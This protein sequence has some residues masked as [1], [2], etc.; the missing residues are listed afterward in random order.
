MDQPKSVL[1]S[2]ASHHWTLANG[3]SV[4]AEPMPHLRSAA[5][6]LLVPAGLQYEPAARLGLAGLACE[7]SQRGAGARD[8]RALLEA[9]DDLGI[10][11]TSS[12]GTFHTAFAG[13]MPH[14]SLDDALELYAD[15]VQRP[16]LP[17][18]E[19]DEVQ[20]LALQ[21]IRANEDEPAQRLMQRIRLAQY[22]EPLGR[23][24]QGTQS[25]VENSTIDELQSFIQTFYQP[26]D[27]ILSVAGR[28]ELD[29]LRERVDRLFGQWQSRPSSTVNL[30]EG[31]PGYIHLEQ[32]SHQVHI[33]LAMPA[34]PMNDPEYMELR[35]AVGILSDGATSRLFQRIREER[36]LC[37][38]VYATCHS[39]RDRGAV[40]C[41]SGTSSDR[42]QE[43][44]DLLLA[45]LDRLSQGLEPGELERLKIRLQSSLIMEQESCAARV[46]AMASDW[47]YLRRIRSLE[48]IQDQVDRLTEQTIINHWR[49]H[50]PRDLRI[51]TVGPHP[52]Q[53]GL[54]RFD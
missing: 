34:V 17:A 19:L 47:F 45:E 28:F 51:V 23:S 26:Q 18:D 36:G 2:I 31:N 14:D 37:Y 3:L 13:A 42:A 12:V 9:M 39:L 33:G 5:V 32:A 44:L 27:A 38:T 16:H 10:E 20:Q 48:E 41:Y 22:G 53:V 4:L 49:Q 25:G 15:I 8:S 24:P 40:F 50:P 11:R 21:E 29:W 7:L 46:G 35:G 52:L 30:G 6:S 1:P 43:T 54:P